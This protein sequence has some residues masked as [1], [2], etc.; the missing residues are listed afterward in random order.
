[1]EFFFFAGVLFC[2]YHSLIIRHETDS[3]NHNEI[4]VVYTDAIHNNET[5]YNIATEGITEIVDFMKMLIQ[6]YKES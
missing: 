4:P 2:I 3:G 1:M 5:F 6:S